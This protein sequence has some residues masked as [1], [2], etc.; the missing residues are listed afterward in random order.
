MR[1]LKRD[2]IMAAAQSQTLANKTGVMC[3]AVILSLTEQSGRRAG[4]G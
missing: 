2:R 3:C 4:A 1:D